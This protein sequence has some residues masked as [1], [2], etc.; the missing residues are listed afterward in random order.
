MWRPWCRRGPWRGTARHPFGL[1]RAPGGPLTDRFS[2]HVPAWRARPPGGAPEGRGGRGGR[3]EGARRGQRGRAGAVRQRAAP[4]DPQDPQGPGAC[5]FPGAAG[6]AAGEPVIEVGF[7][8][9][10]SATTPRPAPP[11][12]ATAPR[13]ATPTTPRRRHSPCRPAPPFPAGPPPRSHDRRSRIYPAR[14]ELSVSQCSGCRA[15]W[16]I[17]DSRAFR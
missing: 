15:D 13:P 16:R 4:Q 12:L 5:F 3:G 6:R 7:G 17:C 1:A 11:H 10:G 14:C 2:P 9:S 8:F